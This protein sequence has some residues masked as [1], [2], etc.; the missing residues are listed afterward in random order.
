LKINNYEASKALGSGSWCI[1]R[2]ESHFD[3]YAGKADKLQFFVFDYTKES[4][5]KMSMI[6]ITLNKDG[7]HSAAHIKNDDPLY[8][9]DNKFLALQKTIITENMHLFELSESMKKKLKEPTE[10]AVAAPK[11]IKN[12]L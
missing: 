7:T 2:H 6:G 3:S 10:T 8:A 1:S 9:K 12:A 5:D 4:N 11:K